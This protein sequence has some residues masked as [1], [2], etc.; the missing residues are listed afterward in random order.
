MM[1]RLS[2]IL[3]LTCFIASGLMA[4]EPEPATTAASASSRSAKTAGVLSVFPEEIRLDTARDYQA[5]LAVVKREDDVT[6]DVTDSVKWTVANEK[7]AKI[8]GNRLLP[9]ADGET[10]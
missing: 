7:F 5:F 8:D 9:L 4:V 1:R 3:V 10:D 6:L 2:A